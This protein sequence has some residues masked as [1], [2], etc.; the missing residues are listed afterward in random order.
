LDE[1]L[2][3]AAQRTY[4]AAHYAVNRSVRAPTDSESLLYLPWLGK[5]ATSGS[6]TSNLCW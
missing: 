6:P 2:V 5:D 4:T 1:V 3:T